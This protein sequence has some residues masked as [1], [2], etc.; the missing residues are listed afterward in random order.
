M[1]LCHKILFSIVC[2]LFLIITGTPKVKAAAVDDAVVTFSECLV[3]RFE[4]ESIQDGHIIVNWEYSNNYTADYDHGDYTNPYIDIIGF[5]IQVCTDAD[6]PVDKVITYQ[7]E[8]Y[9][10]N[11]KSAG[12]TYRIPV[13]S[14]LEK[15]GG[16]L[17]ARI[18]AY[19]RIRTI[20]DPF[21]FEK[22]TNLQVGDI[23]YS[24]YQNLTCWDGFYCSSNFEENM[25]RDHCEYVKISKNN[26]GGMYALI[27]KGYYNCD[28]DG[29]KSYYDKNH[30][31]WLDPSEIKDITVISNYKFQK[32]SATNQYEKFYKTNTYQYKLSDLKGLKYLPWVSMIDIRDF[33]SEKLDLSQYRHIVSVYMREFLDNKFQLIAPYVKEIDLESESGGTWPQA[34]LTSIDVSK[35]KSVRKLTLYGS[36]SK[37]ISIKLPAKATNLRWI[38][39]AYIN[40]KTL[41]LNKFKQLDLAYF[42]SNKFTTCKFDRCTKLKYVYF[43]CC[44]QISSVDLHYAK[45]LKGIDIYYCKK[46]NTE[47]IKSPK[48]AK[49]T[50]NQGRWWESTKDW[51]K[52]FS[53]I[54]QSFY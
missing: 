21:S 29:N 14:V 40:T 50:I 26:F 8:N 12:Y 37:Y 53:D 20:E 44:N 17:Y 30:D 11:V 7:T 24:N 5:E 46:L 47:E 42:Y 1:K 51:Q 9:I 41:N 32:S 49:I 15:E 45:A 39:L 36:Y 2:F 43:Y 16:K 54:Y 52:I 34:K 10:D 25:K 38:S 28:T 4:M 22:S 23:V 13:S 6:Y 3:Y 31:G 27:K 33:T 35:C 18:R 48:T 19:G